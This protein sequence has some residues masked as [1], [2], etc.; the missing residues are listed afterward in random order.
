MFFLTLPENTFDFV[1]QKF[2]KHIK[3]AFTVVH[4]IHYWPEGSFETI[5]FKKFWIFASLFKLASLC[6]WKFA[7]KVKNA[8][9]KCSGDWL[10]SKVSF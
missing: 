3:I 4:N 10:A 6:H 7:K 5:E 8:I 1:A 2:A 9:L